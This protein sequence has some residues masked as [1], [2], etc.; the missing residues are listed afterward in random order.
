MEKS[1]QTPLEDYASINDRPKKRN[2]VNIPLRKNQ[3]ELESTRNYYH[4]NIEKE[5]ERK[6]SDY[7]NKKMPLELFVRFI[8]ICWLP[9]F[10][11]F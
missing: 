5:R 7:H 3:N 11:S 9:F 8:T 4:K 6:R 10:L 2:E 1:T